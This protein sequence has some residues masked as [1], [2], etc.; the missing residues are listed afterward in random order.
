MLHLSLA[1]PRLNQER[2]GRNMN[3]GMLFKLLMTLAT[4]SVV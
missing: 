1:T 4:P 3:G 2:K